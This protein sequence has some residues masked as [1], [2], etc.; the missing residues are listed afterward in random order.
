MIAADDGFKLLKVYAVAQRRTLDDGRVVPWIDENL[1]PT[2]GDWIS[3]TLLRQRH[4]H[5]TERGKDYNH[6]T[7]CDLIISGLIG[8]R[9]RADD[10]VEVHP[11]VPAD[12]SY[13]CLDR[14]RY[15]GRELTILFDQSGTHYG[16]GRGL[17]VLADGKEIAAA[18]NVERVTGQLPDNAPVGSATGR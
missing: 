5:P 17:R 1:N 8:L 16:R 3:R 9:P 6:S 12:W 4:H 15:H 18:K 2:N 13:F 10:T 14:I 11:L 7:F